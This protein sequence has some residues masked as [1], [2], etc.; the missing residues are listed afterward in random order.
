MNKF[1]DKV[2]TACSY[3]KKRSFGQNDGSLLLLS[4]E[5]FSAWWEEPISTSKRNDVLVTNKA[6]FTVSQKKQHNFGYDRSSLVKV[7]K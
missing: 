7:S 3:G 2:G 6:A 5:K 4:K 1:L